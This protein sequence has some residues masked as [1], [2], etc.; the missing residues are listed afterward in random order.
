MIEAVEALKNSG[1]VIVDDNH[2]WG[3]Q[4]RFVNE[5]EY[6]GKLLILENRKPGSLHY[7]KVK[8]E[9]F[10]VLFGKVFIHGYKVVCECTNIAYS[11]VV[12]EGEIVTLEPYMVHEMVNML[13]DISVILEVST[14]DDDSDTYRVGGDQV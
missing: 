2:E 6:C 1:N 14:H 5:D 11:N 13:D 4:L 10:I 7:H 9:T 12:K 3:Y 8:K